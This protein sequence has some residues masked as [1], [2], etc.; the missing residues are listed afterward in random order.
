MVFNA[1]SGRTLGYNIP[2][3]ARFDLASG[4]NTSRT[5]AAS[6]RDVW[7]LSTWV[8]RGA[9][10]AAQAIFVGATGGNDFSAIAF[11]TSNQIDYT[12][13]D[14]NA[15]TDLVSTLAQFRDP[16]AWFHLVVAMDTTAGGAGTLQIYINGVE[17]VYSGVNYP[18]AGVDTDFNA[19]VVHYIGANADGTV[20]ADLYLADFHW[21]DGTKLTPSSFGALDSTTGQW[22]AKTFTGAHGTEG[23]Y[24]DFSNSSD[25]GSDQS[26]NANDLTDAG[27]TTADQLTDTPTNNHCTINP[28][29]PVHGVRATYS[30]GN[31]K[32]N[33]TNAGTSSTDHG[34]IAVSS[35]KYYFECQAVTVGGSEYPYIGVSTPEAVSGNGTLATSWAY[36]AATGKKWNAN[37]G[38]AYGTARTALDIIGV[39]VDLDNGKIWF[40]EN[41]VYPA[42]GD[43]AAGTNAAYTNL[44]GE[45]LLPAFMS[46][47]SFAGLFNF[48]QS[49]FAGTI[50]VGF[51]TLCAVDLSVPTIKD[52]ALQFHVEAYTGTGGANS[53]T[54]FGFGVG[55]S[56]IKNRD[57]ADNWRVVDLVRGATKELVINGTADEATNANGLTSFDSDGI[58]LGTGAGGYNDSAEDFVAYNWPLAGA[59][60]ANSDGTITSTATS[61]N[62]TAGVSVVTYTGNGLGGATVGHGLGVAPAMII[63]KARS[64]VGT[65]RGWTVYHKKNTAAPETDYLQL[66]T[67]AAT[68][69]EVQV[70]NDTVPSTSVFSIGTSAFVNVSGD[71][72]VAYCFAEIPGFSKFGSY[73]GNGAADGA[74]AHMGFSPAFLLIKNTT[75]AGQGWYVYDV[76]RDTINES[77]LPLVINTA[78]AESAAGASDIVS[79]GWKARASGNTETNASGATMIYA[80]FA[81]FP[82]KYA[83][84]R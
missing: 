12:H 7:T 69:D 30:E 54:G 72:F 4:N 17:A 5:P 34:T 78:A 73:V 66:D 3:S 67:T 31:L 15:V 19:A 76:K 8:K 58:T 18:A 51:S 23:F 68:A 21:V 63:V 22:K 74:F 42:S 25:F 47:N 35:G 61:V 59:G 83:N 41:D 49:A 81:E 75:N 28:L 52:P 53:L 14:A 38:V 64:T 56:W 79:N 39:A 13:V 32:V 65:D 24:L 45:I 77:G 43:P 62:T 36:D 46:Y 10:G 50:P 60:S 84:A 11:N 70:W 27:F 44:T 2:Y 57:A 55:M 6:N 37:S 71:T 82:F 1:T 48:G 29:E 16:S 26:G 33:N 80:A 40:S 20:N 9:L